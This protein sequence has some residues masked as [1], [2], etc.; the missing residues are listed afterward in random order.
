MTDNISDMDR[1]RQRFTELGF[2]VTAEELTKVA[3]AIAAV[4]K[5]IRRLQEID[6][7]A[8]EPATIFIPESPDADS[9]SKDCCG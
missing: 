7:S 6:V 2:D 1:L 5:S 3:P 9:E 4:H 8:Y